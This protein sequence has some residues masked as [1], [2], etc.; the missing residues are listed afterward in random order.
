MFSTFFKHVQQGPESINIPTVILHNG[1]EVNQ[2]SFKLIMGALEKLSRNNY[3]ALYQ[4]IKKCNTG[5]EIT[6]YAKEELVKSGL[7][8]INGSINSDT[9][10]IVLS[11][12]KGIGPDRVMT[13]IDP[14]KL[15][16]SMRPKL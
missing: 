12:F 9:R 4:L 3:G 16:H 13:L 6:G 1:A 7:I 5:R 11:A 10:N 8:S 14:I 2:S 15:S